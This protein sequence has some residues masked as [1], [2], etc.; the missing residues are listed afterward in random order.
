MPPPRTARCDKAAARGVAFGRCPSGR[1]QALPPPPA[2]GRA[3][4]GHGDILLDGSTLPPGMRHGDD[5]GKLVILKLRPWALDSSSA[6][7][8]CE[9]NEVLKPTGDAA[10]VGVEHRPTD[11][12]RRGPGWTGSRRA[13]G[14]RLARQEG[15]RR[16]QPAH[17]SVSPSLALPLSKISKNNFKTYRCHV[18][19]R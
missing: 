19:A 18:P 6:A 5:S 9:A 4:P 2:G 7:T 15:A 11:H 13:P 12:G 3:R 1:E 14:L 8:A 17:V 10:W 16:R